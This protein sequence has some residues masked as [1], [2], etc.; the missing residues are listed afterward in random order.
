MGGLESGRGT[1]DG[2]YNPGQPH[3]RSAVTPRAWL[4]L[5]LSAEAL[6]ADGPEE[7]D[8]IRIQKGMF[9]LSDRG[10]AR[11]AYEFRP[12]NWGPFSSQIYQDLEALERRGL[13]ESRRLPGRTWRAYQTTRVGDKRAVK[14][15]QQLDPEHVRWLG[16]VRE[17]LTDRSFVQLLREI[18]RVYPQ[19]KPRSLLR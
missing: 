14:I 13:V 10:P 18:Y 1:P 5:L 16:R 11:G 17:F 3:D 4:L 6:G 15:A 9:L 8:P 2:L 12:Y 7:L 19:Y